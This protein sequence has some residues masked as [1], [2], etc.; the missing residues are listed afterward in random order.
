MFTYR[1]YIDGS[2][3]VERLDH[4][5]G[6]ISPLPHHVLHSPCGFNWGYEGSGPSELARCLLIDVIG[7][8]EVVDLHG[9]YQLF[10]RAYVAHW[11]KDES[12]AITTNEI[13]HWWNTTVTDHPDKNEDESSDGELSLEELADYYREL[14]RLE[15]NGERSPMFIGPYTAMILINCLQNT[16]RNSELGQ[17]QHDTIRAFIEQFRPWF[18]G[19]LGEQI[20]NDIDV[21]R[22]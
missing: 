9:R 3:I 5:T 11:T 10:K 13:T 8:E 21:G 2:P 4:T 15:H 1:G 17:L 14:Q 7:N 6:E 18:Q 16:L 20:I 12:W 19:T 22:L